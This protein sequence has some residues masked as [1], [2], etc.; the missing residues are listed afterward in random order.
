[1]TTRLPGSRSAW[2]RRPD[3]PAVWHAQLE[4]ALATGDADGFWTAVQHLPADRF[5]APTI[6]AYRAWLAARN[7]DPEQEDRELASLIDSEPG[8]T[9]AL[10]RLAVLKVESGR[11]RE[12]ESLRRRKAEVDQAQDAYR[13]VLLDGADQADRENV[14]AKLASTL[15]RTFEAQAW[16]I[17]AD[18]R[19]RNE[20]DLD[21]PDSASQSA[22]ELRAAVTARAT[23]LSAPYG[24][25]AER[26]AKAG[27]M[28]ADRLADLR[29]EKSARPEKTAPVGISRDD[30]ASKRA[31]PDFVDDATAAGLV[32]QFDNGQTALHLIPESQSGGVG[33]I[34]FDGDGWLDVYC[35][36]GG[37]LDCVDPAALDRAAGRGRPALSEQRRRH[38]STTLPRNP[39]SPGSPGDK[40]T[41][42][43]S[44]SVTTTTTAGPISS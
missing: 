30:G 31:T 10:E 13:K 26:V 33:V 34:D 39:A 28:L 20:L 43:A 44:P 42:W 17:L 25:F 19:P 24:V 6:L 36:Q 35:V 7:H 4:L 12:A 8:N 37:A 5:D 1:M 11:P 21:D 40:A 22:A 23:A 9:K 3:D 32:F 41:A 29:P 18:A 16:S 2:R 15:G 14:L 27:P 38:I